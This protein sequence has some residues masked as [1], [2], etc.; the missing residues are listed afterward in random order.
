MLRKLLAGALAILALVSGMIVLFVVFLFA[1]LK[2]DRTPTYSVPLDMQGPTS[3]TNLEVWVTEPGNYAVALR[4]PYSGGVEREKAWALAGGD[5]LESG[6]WREPGSALVFQ[7]RIQEIASE[8][9]MLNQ[10]VMH[11]ELDS[12]A[13]NYLNADLVKRTLETGHYQVTVQREG[14]LAD[15]PPAPLEI[16]FGKAHQGK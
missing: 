3:T 9:E 12:W 10:Q 8:I 2:P 15:T 6:T 5:T 16:H 4:Y 14:N 1:Q 13:G 11:P 7:V